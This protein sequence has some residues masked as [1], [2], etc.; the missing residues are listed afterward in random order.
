MSLVLDCNVCFEIGNEFRDFNSDRLSRNTQKNKTKNKKTKP[1]S[2]NQKQKTKPKTKINN[3]VLLHLR[4]TLH[5]LQT[6]HFREKV[7][8]RLVVRSM[9][10]FEPLILSATAT[11]ALLC[12]RLNHRLNFLASLLIQVIF[13][14]LVC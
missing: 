12:R 13:K 10:L 11:F 5:Q 9:A 4:N 14:H 3:L 8:L 6:L 7:T 2:K 1:K